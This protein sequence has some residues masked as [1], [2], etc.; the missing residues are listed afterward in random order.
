MTA[1]TDYQEGRL[2]P[3]LEQIA[4]ALEFAMALGEAVVRKI[5]ELLGG[6]DD[7][8]RE[9]STSS[10][11]RLPRLLIAQPV[12]DSGYVASALDITRRA[13]KA[14]LDR[15]CAYGILRPCGN[16]RRGEFYQCDEVLDL[17][18]EM[19]DVTGMRRMLAGHPK[20]GDR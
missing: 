9:R 5:E 6:W 12:V 8:I 16:K 4:A 15:A 2:D 10:I 17:L 7:A 11:Y 20:A 19:A 3:M 18:D 1:I 14:L 13:A